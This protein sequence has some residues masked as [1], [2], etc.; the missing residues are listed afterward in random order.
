MPDEKPSF[1]IYLLT[2]TLISVSV[3][4]GVID[5]ELFVDRVIDVASEH[6]VMVLDRVLMIAAHL[7][8]V[9]VELSINED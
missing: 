3:L 1:N 2:K 8:L 7:A 6:Q 9:S 4:P 5:G